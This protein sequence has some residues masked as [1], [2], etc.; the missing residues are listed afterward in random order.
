MG[1]IIFKKEQIPAYDPVKILSQNAK[2]SVK[3]TDAAN[4]I[5]DN[6]FIENVENEIKGSILEST[7]AD[8]QIDRIEKSAEVLDKENL[9][10]E[11]YFKKHKPILN[12]GGIDVACDLT[13]MRIMFCIMVLPYFFTAVLIKTPLRVVSV[14]FEE[15]NKMFLSIASFSKPAKIFFLIIIWYGI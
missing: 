13:V 5:K 4:T 8:R 15:F 1:E 7:K 2:E 12:F 9:K 10:N 11:N 3:F 6:S 14:F